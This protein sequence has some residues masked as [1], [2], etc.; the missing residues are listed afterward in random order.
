MSV[1][2]FVSMYLTLCGV[3]L[4]E[5]MIIHSTMHL[6]FLQ[7]WNLH[8]GSTV[9]FFSSAFLAPSWIFW[10]PQQ[11]FSN[12]EPFVGLEYLKGVCLVLLIFYDVNGSLYF[13]SIDC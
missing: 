9:F 10:L 1:I 5:H 12:G 13:I 4:L 11:D 8:W 2:W 3:L 7:K 6:G